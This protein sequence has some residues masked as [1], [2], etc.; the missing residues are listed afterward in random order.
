MARLLSHDGVELEYEAGGDG[1]AVLL[2]H[3]YGATGR[4]WDAQRAA[5]DDYRLITWDMRGHGRTDS[6]A[7]PARYSIEA[8]VADMRALLLHFGEARAVIDALPLIRVPTLIVVGE[9][10][11]AFLAPGEYM[12]KKI[13]GARLEVIPGAGHASNLDRPDVFNHVLRDFLSRLAL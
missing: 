9:R 10:D 4:M 13:P 1:A 2:T 7:H 8:T 12:A 5:L 6:P 3:G 11:A